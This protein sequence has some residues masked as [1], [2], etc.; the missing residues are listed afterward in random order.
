MEDILVVKRRLLFPKKPFQGISKEDYSNLILKNYEYRKRDKKLE[1]NTQFKQIIT[2]VWLVNKKKK[3]V[4]LYKRSLSNGKY[5]EKR[6]LNKYSAGVGGHV[7]KNSEG[8]SVNPLWSAMIRELKEE[9]LMK[10]YP[11]PKIIGYIND[12]EGKM[13]KFHFGL[14]AV[15]N[16]KGKIKPL[17]GMSSGILY[18]IKEMEKLFKNKNNKV[19]NWTKLS[20]PVV[21]NYLLEE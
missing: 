20:W 13:E 1:N 12:E 6:L 8:K 7:D 18:S 2:Y 5:K 4:F 17:E 19:E 9:V 11:T 15:A 3:K 10:V 16:T 21:K 14:L